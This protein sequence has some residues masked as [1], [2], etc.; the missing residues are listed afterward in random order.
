M[1]HLSSATKLK[2][3]ENSGTDIS[4]IFYNSTK[5]VLRKSCKSRHIPLT[6]SFQNIKQVTLPPHN[7]SRLPY[8]YYRLQ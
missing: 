1:A 6:K 4:L 8:F 3:K 2:V 5:I 7:F